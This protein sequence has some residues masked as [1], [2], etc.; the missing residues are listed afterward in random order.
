MLQILTIGGNE[1][2]IRSYGEY[3][4]RETDDWK[5]VTWN[6]IDEKSDLIIFN[7]EL[8]IS[9]DWIER[10]IQSANSYIS[11]GTVSPML[12][13][14]FKEYD[15]DKFVKYD[16][17]TLREWGRIFE[18][19]TLGNCCDVEWNLFDCVYIKSEVL[20]DVGIPTEEMVLDKNKAKEWFMTVAQLGWSSVMTNDVVVS[21]RLIYGNSSIYYSSRV[22]GNV[23][24]FIDDLW[25]CVELF[26][27]LHF[28][29]SRINIL[30][31]LLADFQEGRAYNIGGTQF[32][33]SD[34]V[35]YQKK[36]YNVFV[37][38]RDGGYLRLTE[39]VDNDKKQF[40]FWVGTAS[41]NV[42]FYDKR[43]EEV[44][45]KILKVFDIRLIHIHHTMWMPLNIFYAANSYYI[46]IIM[47]IHD[48]Y[49][50]C[51]VL[52]M[53]NLQNEL[54]TKHTCE[55]DCNECLKK[56]KNI[57]DGTAYINKWHREYGK[58]IDLCSK[59]ISPSQQALDTI[60][61]FYPQIHNKAFIVEHGIRLPK[62]SNKI[63]YK[64]DKLRIAFIGGISDIKGGSVIYD[65]I[66]KDK[67]Q[68]E[69]YIMGK[70]GY[71]DLVYLEQKNLTKTGQYKRY[72]I[73]DLLK[74]HEIDI[75]CILSIVAETFCYTLS[76]AAAMGIPVIAKRV[77]ALG[78]RAEKMQCGWV[79]PR[80][81]NADELYS[82][83][84]QINNNRDEYNFFKERLEKM[85]NRNIEDMGKEY[86]D[87]YQL[88]QTNR[89][90]ADLPLMLP[91]VHGNKDVVLA[92]NKYYV[93]EMTRL[94]EDEKELSEIKNLYLVQLMLKI[95]RLDGFFWRRLKAGIRHI[96]RL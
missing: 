41:D 73:Y 59:I 50:A 82:L 64:H 14:D 19:C 51:P 52:K 91:Y 30:H 92:D 54:C 34:L 72:E 8:E 58:V 2:T 5:M 77:G 28:D 46:P 3:N 26:F 81:T 47:S 37:L 7:S 10:L 57:I 48:Y 86:D 93:E 25:K 29:N 22:K 56:T 43:H 55:S 21:G 23:R 53:I 75:V 40:D 60:G 17:Q 79:I 1:Q 89:K 71:S 69:W 44:Y 24:R 49:Y 18:A 94:I 96:F 13:Q 74:L 16:R 38:A 68:F 95:Y 32:H 63:N 4:T 80:D 76:E 11:I 62:E 42:I 39:Y 15:L 66:K 87:I 9:D 61:E 6:S 27:I 88:I 70:I 90:I 35:E 67:S 85:D 12:L 36:K 78:E 45:L 20:C 83:L 65:L 84:C 33:V 31:Y